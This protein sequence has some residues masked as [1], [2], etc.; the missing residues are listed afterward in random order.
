[1]ASHFQR[2]P[3]RKFSIALLCRAGTSLRSQ[4]RDNDSA[5]VKDYLHKR[6]RRACV[7]DY[8]TKKRQS[9]KIWA[10]YKACRSGPMFA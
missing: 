8:G 6:K 10:S 4:T 1:M 3:A 9:K 2:I 7:C 5:L